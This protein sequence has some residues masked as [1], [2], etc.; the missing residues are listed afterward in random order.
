MYIPKEF[1]IHDRIVLQ[2]FLKNHPFGILQT[3]APDFSIHSTHIPFLCVEND[4]DLF[5][6]E[7]H[8]ALANEQAIDL[9]SGSTA[10]LIVQGAHGYVSSSVYTH[11]NVPTYNYQ[12][13]HVFGV[14]H[15][16]TDMELRTHLKLVVDTFEENR[17]LPLSFEKWPTEMIDDYSK[18]IV[19][20]RLNVNRIE[21]AF[22]CSQNRN[23]T[24]FNRIVEDLKQG[25]LS[26]QSLAES[27]ISI[28]KNQFK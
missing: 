9:F 26:D 3:V 25:D 16:M 23:E 7:G 1:Q 14:I 24:D 12:A 20:F 15:R 10:Q 11:I 19:G 5:G 4:G 6:L 2:D 27:M 17:K 8:I 13:V 21:G 28:R 18:Q 22:K